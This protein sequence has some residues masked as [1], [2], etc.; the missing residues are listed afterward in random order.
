MNTRRRQSTAAAVAPRAPRIDVV[1]RQASVLS[2]VLVL[3]L[4][5]SLTGSG[6]G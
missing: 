6:Y 4:I 5:I 1:L 3:V 2:L